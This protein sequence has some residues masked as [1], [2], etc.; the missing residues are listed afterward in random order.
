MKN[1][2][3]FGI[4]ARLFFA[5]GSVVSMTLIASLT[6]WLLINDFNN[7]L[8]HIVTDTIPSVTL[9]ARLAKSGGVIIATAPALASADNDPQRSL[10][11]NT[12]QE[13]INKINALI[14]K[15]LFYNGDK[16]YFATLKAVINSVSANLRRLDTNVRQRLWYK[17][18]NED[19]VERLRWTHADFIDEIEP[20]IDDARFEI[21]LALSRGSI[22]DNQG[23]L[24]LA[25]NHSQEAL[26]KLSSKVNLAIGLISKTASLTTLDSLKNTEYYL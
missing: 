3:R 22:Y 23:P 19:L 7:N 21:E 13:N 18:R 4:R 15:P 1:M 5:F 25:G 11:W 2:L 24:L 17:E 9:A 14:K 26:L 6:G 8:Q 12:L 20:M 16:D 10:V